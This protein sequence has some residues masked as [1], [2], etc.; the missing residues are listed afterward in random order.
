ME[1]EG[2]VNLRPDTVLGKPGTQLIAACSPDDVLVEDVMGTGIDPG[3]HEAVFRIGARLDDSGCGEQLVITRSKDAPA[4]I[5]LFHVT[6]FHKQD[7]GL[8]SIQ[9]AV[10]A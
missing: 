7:R 9:A 10:S 2:V 6:Q 4:L 1:R 8:Q 3:E 5:P